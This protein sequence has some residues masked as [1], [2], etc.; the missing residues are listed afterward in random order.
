MKKT[1]AM[2]S[3]LA[4]VVMA[5]QIAEI[6]AQEIKKIESEPKRS[7][8]QISTGKPTTLESGKSTVELTLVIDQGFAINTN[9]PAATETEP[10]LPFPLSLEFLDDDGGV[11]DAK[12][13]YPKGTDVKSAVG[14]YRVYTGKIKLAVSF[15]KLS[16]VRTL[17]VKFAGYRFMGHVE[18]GFS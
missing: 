14:D 7:L 8:I 1:T 13:I 12:I 6:H 17:R 5:I 9:K 2:V 3:L 16:S 10:F 4:F 11:V 15:S 18:S